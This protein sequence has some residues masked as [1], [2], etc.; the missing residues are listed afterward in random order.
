VE[1]MKVKCFVKKSPLSTDLC[2][3]RINGK[4]WKYSGYRFSDGQKRL[5]KTDIFLEYRMVHVR[6]V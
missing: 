5:T 2:K 1:E 6:E 3:Q 4:G